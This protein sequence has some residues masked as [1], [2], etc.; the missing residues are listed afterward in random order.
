MI[1]ILEV[2]IN[3]IVDENKL[4]GALKAIEIVMLYSFEMKFE[5]YEDLMNCSRE[6][7]CKDYLLSKEE[8]TRWVKNIKVVQATYQTEFSATLKKWKESPIKNKEVDTVKKWKDFLYAT[9]KDYKLRLKLETEFAKIYLKNKIEEDFNIKKS[10]EVELLKKEVP[11][12]KLDMITCQPKTAFGIVEISRKIV[13]KG[14]PIDFSILFSLQPHSKHAELMGY[15]NADVVNFGGKGKYFET[16]ND[17][18]IRELI[19]EARIDAEEYVTV[20]NENAKMSSFYVVNIN[21]P[22]KIVE[23]ETNQQKVY[24]ITK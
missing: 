18:L 19:E 1:K 21:D 15:K 14:K 17:V 11:S 22:W 13:E 7:I 9:V 10:K 5:N 24:K 16:E 8:E 23:S 2:E 12:L 6:F 4:E 3:K 20:L